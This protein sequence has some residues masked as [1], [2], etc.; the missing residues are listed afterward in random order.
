M[1]AESVETVVVERDRGFH[2]AQQAEEV[3]E[4]CAECIEIASTRSAAII[5]HQRPPS[6]PR[7]GFLRRASPSGRRIRAWS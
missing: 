2:S 3:A 1:S 5:R 6:M 7:Y 4:E